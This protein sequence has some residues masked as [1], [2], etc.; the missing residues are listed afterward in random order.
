MQPTIRPTFTAEETSNNSAQN[1]STH[2]LQLQ[3]SLSLSLSLSLSVSVSQ[4]SATE[5]SHSVSSYRKLCVSLSLICVSVLLDWLV[6]V[7]AGGKR[8]NKRWNAR[9]RALGYSTVI[10]KLP[11]SCP[12]DANKR[13][14]VQKKQQQQQQQQQ[15]QNNK[16]QADKK[17]KRAKEGKTSVATNEA[18]CYFINVV[19]LYNNR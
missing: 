18:A 4:R 19:V 12:V 17:Q 3:I 1:S 16:V 2:K 6:S 7:K 9:A 13:K 15:Q 10:Q 5:I 14:L 11:C 8:S